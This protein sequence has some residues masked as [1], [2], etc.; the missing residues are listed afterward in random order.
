MH[1]P[2]TSLSLTIPVPS[3]T[4]Q[5]ALVDAAHSAKLI[6]VAH[7]LSLS[8]TMAMLSC[9]ID[10]LTH[11]FF[12]SPPP[13]TLAAAYRA[14]NAHCNPTLAAIG[15]LTTEG[16]P[17]QLAFAADPLA[18][19]LLDDAARANLTLCMGAGASSGGSVAHAYASVRA[20]HQAGVPVVVG[21]DAA[22][23]ARGT[24]YGL[25][26]HQELRLLVHE[27]GMSAEEALAAATGVTAER[28]G[29]RDRGVLEVGRRADLVLLSGDVVDCLEVVGGG[30]HGLCLPVLG[31]WREGVVGD[32]WEGVMDGRFVVSVFAET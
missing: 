9:G 12:D 7:A 15:S 32:V 22:G 30:A 27:C 24:A 19:R 31:V 1:E 11:T 26:V 25:S 18:R 5:K 6:A 23:P 28:F 17:Q 16:Q 3:L 4:L 10:G 21:S 14:N 13:A 29:F 2:G 8:A 20:L